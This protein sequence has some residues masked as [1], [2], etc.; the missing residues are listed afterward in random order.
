MFLNTTF[1]SHVSGTVKA[2]YGLVLKF[3]KE[4]MVEDYSK[5]KFGIYSYVDRLIPLN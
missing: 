3:G 5:E 2:R 4:K 1:K